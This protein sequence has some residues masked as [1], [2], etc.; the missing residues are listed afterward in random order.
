MAKRTPVRGWL[1]KELA[2]VTTELTPDRGA[3]EIPIRLGG[4]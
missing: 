4:W 3:R 2:S 1:F